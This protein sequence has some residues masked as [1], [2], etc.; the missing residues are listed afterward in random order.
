MDRQ[1]LL[2]TLFHGSAWTLETTEIPRREIV[3]TYKGSALRFLD[4]VRREVTG[5]RS[6]STPPLA[7][8]NPVALLGEKELAEGL[9]LE[10]YLDREE[11]WVVAPERF[12]KTAV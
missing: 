6:L 10:V 12:F 8:R 1:V 7:G 5:T 9:A 11:G 3:S 2:S 4:L